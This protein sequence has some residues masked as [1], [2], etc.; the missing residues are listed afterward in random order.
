MRNFKFDISIQMMLALVLG[1]IIGLVLNYYDLT[2]VLIKPLGDLFLSLIKMVVVPLVFITLTAGVAKIGQ[3]SRIGKIAIKTLFYYFI[4]SII[5]IILGFIVTNLVKFSTNLPIDTAIQYSSNTITDPQD[6]ISLILSIIPTN[7]IAALTSGN[8]LQI[9]FFSILLGI[10]IS[11]CKSRTS[12]VIKFFD[13]LNYVIIKLTGL[14]MHY[15]PI[16]TFAL[17]CYTVASFGIEV[18][19]PLLKL[20]LLMYAISLLHVLIVYLPL[21]LYCSIG[22]KKFFTKIA[23]P[24]I[25][26][27]STCSSAA[28]LSENMLSVEKLGVP[29]TISSFSIPLGNTIN[30]DGAAI[31]LGI[32]I[33][34]ASQIFN[35]PLSMYDYLQA[36]LLGLLASIGSVGMPGAI[37]IMM[38]TMFLSL[39]LPIETIALV[40]GIDRLMDMARTPMNILGDAV[41]ACFV[42]KS[43]KML[44]KP[45]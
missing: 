12:T 29:R 7:P 28:A 24:L 5:A 1:T 39:G 23:S 31:Y 6:I 40:A 21:I 37:L 4:T 44:T 26:A 3:T 9:M 22:I 14:I 16:G 8:I 38:S 15:A 30:M 34:F 25:I 33:V 17:I 43:E 32:V 10:A 18:M 36:I 19:L 42:A 13:E 2:P 35:I 11:K 20:I 41:G 45:E 27:C